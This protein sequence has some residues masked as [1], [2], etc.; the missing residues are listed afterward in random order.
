MKKNRDFVLNPYVRLYLPL[1]KRD[2]AKIASDDAYGHLCTVTGAVWGAQGRTIDATDDHIVI[3]AAETLLFGTGDFTICAWFKATASATNKVVIGN[4]NG[5]NPYYLLRVS[6]TTGFAYFAYRDTGVNSVACQD[7]ADL[8]GAFHF[9]MGTRVGGTACLYVDGA[10]VSTNTDAAV[11]GSVNTGG[12]DDIGCDYNG[13]TRRWF[14][15]GII[16]EL[17]AYKG[18]ALTLPEV[19]NLYLATKWRYQ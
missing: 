13:G 19:Q 10:L 1:W 15:N 3:G 7:A 16:G 4:D 14:A 18:K 11:T 5:G 6:A 8:T 12:L 9:L 2:G 17:A